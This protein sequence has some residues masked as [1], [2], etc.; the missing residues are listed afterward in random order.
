MR[1][2]IQI[3]QFDIET[4]STVLNTINTVYL[5]SIGLEFQSCLESLN[6]IDQNTKRIYEMLLLRL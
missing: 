6:F 3:H 4:E 2:L 1:N 5:N